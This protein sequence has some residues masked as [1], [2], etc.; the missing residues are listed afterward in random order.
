LAVRINAEAKA[1]Y[2]KF[3]QSNGALWSGNFRDLT[4]SVM[5]LVTLADGG[6]ITTA[7]TGAEVQRLRWLW[8]RGDAA[9]GVQRIRPQVP[10]MLVAMA[11][12]RLAAN[13]G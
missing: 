5:R 3:A 13:S 4:S 12:A 8:Q 11:D 2:L 9:P 1:L 6:R 7:Q 10:V